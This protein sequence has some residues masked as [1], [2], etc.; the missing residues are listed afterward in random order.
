MK[1]TQSQVSDE[2]VEKKIKQEEVEHTII[3]CHAIMRPEAGS[4]QAII[5]MKDPLD[6]VVQFHDD[7]FK[8]T[9]D[10]N[11]MS[12]YSLRDKRFIVVLPE[13]EHEIFNEKKGF[14]TGTNDADF[15][16]TINII[17][18]DGSK[19]FKIYVKDIGT[20]LNVSIYGKRHRYNDKY[21]KLDFYDAEKNNNLLQIPDID[22]PIFNEDNNMTLVVS[23]FAANSLDMLVEVE[24]DILHPCGTV[25]LD[26]P[27]MFVD[28]SRRDV[29]KFGLR[30]SFIDQGISIVDSLTS[31]D[32]V[33]I[34]IY[35]NSS[36][37]VEL[38]N[39]M[40]T[41]VP[42]IEIQSLMKS[43]RKAITEKY[44]SAPINDEHE[45]REKIKDDLVFFYKQIFGCEVMVRK[46]NRKPKF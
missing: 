20:K 7:K 19:C 42:D 22:M 37:S 3:R 29:I 46:L 13:S 35:N 26:I 38:S 33:R 9:L 5:V 44:N 30:S 18:E 10:R 32:D 45:E 17:D 31:D 15:S 43:I 2:C 36:E 24:K 28:L 41:I 16:E 14:I 27:N 8:I 11:I 34:I 6:V 40:I 1:R 21:D 39:R 4:D 25:L 23:S 12:P